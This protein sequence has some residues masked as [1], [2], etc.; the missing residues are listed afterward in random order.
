MRAVDLHLGAFEAKILHVADDADRRDHPIHGDFL[1]LAAGFDRHG[2]IIRALLRALHRRGGD[3]LHP[4]LLERLARESGN[5]R[6]FHRQDAVHHFHDGHFHAEIA[7]EA[8]EFH[9]DRAGADHQHGFRHL[10][11]HHG[12]EIAP[13][14]LAIDLDAGDLPRPRAGG[15]DD[16]LGRQ[17]GHRLAV[18]GHLELA[19]AGQLA[20]AVEHGDLVLLQ[21]MRDAGRKLLG[22]RARAFDDF[23]QVEFHVIGGKTEFAEIMQQMIDFR[24]A[25]QRLGRDAA[26]V[27]ADAAEMLG[28][29][30]RHLHFQLRR[31]DRRD[32]A[33][34]AAADH[35]QVKF[36][37]LSHLSAP[38][39]FVV[40]AHGRQGRAAQTIFV[41]FGC[42]T[43]P[44]PW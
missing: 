4:L 36:L 2:D 1:L 14:Q 30:H 23:F 16:A 43:A 21:Q 34:R 39:N 11:R 24:G 17:R 27:E 5:F 25:Q 28:L 32:I 38:Q 37:L 10:L 19:R 6:V 3:D 33:A 8:G 9:A 41:P 26:P 7:V 15:E 29:D 31:T 12:L 35:D 40:A 13:D 44:R 20:V 42:A 18:L 22:D